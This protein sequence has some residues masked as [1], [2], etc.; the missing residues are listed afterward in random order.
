MTDASSSLSHK[1]MEK[2]AFKHRLLFPR[3]EPPS[4]SLGPPFVVTK[5]QR[6]GVHNSEPSKGGRYVFFYDW[7]M[8]GL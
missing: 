4:E 7:R 1:F 5:E 2:E 8:F 6:G 3:W